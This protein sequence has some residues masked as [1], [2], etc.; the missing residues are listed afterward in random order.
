MLRV[1]GKA[2][3]YICLGAPP[4]TAP[5][6]VLLHEGLGC[7]SLWRDFPVKLCASTNYG[8]F[9]YSRAGYGQSDSA[10]LPW[11]LDYMTREAIDILPEVI[12]QIDA[13]KVVLVGH[14]DGATIAAIYAG[15]VVDPR[16]VGAV[17]IAPHFFTETK[18]LVEIAKARDAYNNKDLRERLSKYHRD[19]DSAFRGW[20]D[21]WLDPEF[22][23]WNVS[24]VLEDIRMP[25]LVIQGREDPYGTLAQ[26]DAV[27]DSV[28][29]A[30]VSR[31]IIDD[32]QH[33]PHLEHGAMVID[34]ISEF[35]KS[36]A[37]NHQA[38]G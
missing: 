15:R 11:P 5:T 38:P 21:S 18:G 35:C 24:D 9:T 30:S 4:D 26:V 8:V 2:L 33:A 37:I 34:A 10:V 31:L 28:K 29:G 16:V 19:V 25:V 3:E 23:A 32:C 13:R 7:V 27:T 12:D 14:S 36:L 6:I 22:K 17:L 1:D 20:C